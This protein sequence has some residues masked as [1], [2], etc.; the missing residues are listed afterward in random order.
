M[1]F[2]NESNREFNIELVNS[3]MNWDRFASNPDQTEDKMKLH[4]VD[5]KKRVNKIQVLLIK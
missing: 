3:H 5:F 2:Q 1:Y 4:A